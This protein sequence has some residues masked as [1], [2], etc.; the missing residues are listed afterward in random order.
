MVFIQ[1]RE[2]PGGQLEIFDFAH[3]CR[4][5]RHHQTRRTL[6]SEHPLAELH[7]RRE[8]RRRS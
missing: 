5:G 1:L 6:V 2:R 3:M 7:D 4:V 8:I